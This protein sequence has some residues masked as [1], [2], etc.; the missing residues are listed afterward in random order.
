MANLRIGDF[1]ERATPNDG[2]KLLI[3][4]ENNLG[5]YHRVPVSAV[6]TG[7]GG[8]G[9]G[10]GSAQSFEKSVV[11]LSSDTAAAVADERLPL[12]AATA[13]N[14]ASLGWD[15]ANNRW[16]PTKAGWY[17]VTASRQYS[18]SDPNNSGLYVKKNAGLGSEISYRADRGDGAGESVTSP[19]IFCDGVNDYL[20]VW[21]HGDGSGSYTYRG[22]SSTNLWTWGACYRLDPV[23]AA[24]D[25]GG[26]ASRLLVDAYRSTA[27][28]IPGN[29]L[30]DVLF[31][32]ES[33]DLDSEYNPSTGEFT[34]AVAKEVTVTAKARFIFPPDGV[35]L[36]MQIMLDT[37]SGYSV[38]DFVDGEEAGGGGGGQGE[39]LMA[40]KRLQLDAGNK[41]KIAVQVYEATARD[42]GAGAH[43]TWL[44]IVEHSK[45]TPDSRTFVQTES[46]DGSITLTASGGSAPLLFPE[47]VD[48]LGD[49]DPSTG[50]VTIRRTGDYLVIGSIRVT[51]LDSGQFLSL[52]LHK[53]NGSGWDILSNENENGGAFPDRSPDLTMVLP[54]VKGDRIRISANLGAGSNKTL[55]VATGVNYFI[56][57]E[58]PGSPTEYSA[59]EAAWT[60]T[61][62]WSAE[63]T[64][65]FGRKSRQGNELVLRGKISANSAPAN[66]ILE[67]DL[68][69]G[70][71]IDTAKMALGFGGGHTP[72]SAHLRTNDGTSYQLGVLAFSATS[73]R[74]TRIFA[75][76]NGIQINSFTST[77][78]D[79]I[80]AG[81]TLSFEIR[82]PILGWGTHDGAYNFPS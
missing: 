47:I 72:G 21:S 5:Q 57:K 44:Q 16:K 11:Y 38:I 22:F 33:A 30:T 14:D 19:P 49:Y 29:A 43:Q 65:D 78:V 17:Q 63:S 2:D 48:R 3:E 71:Q 73:F 77:N 10:S 66:S 41:L 15:G 4:D 58:L 53:W 70:L 52:Y 24:V 25:G 18:G 35:R 45:S 9:G 12:D 6:G 61:H 34:A 27:Q 37:G 54:L 23:A 46:T 79:T 64:L 82:V 55:A 28:S 36:V 7:G 40:T 74:L 8:G 1:P 76:G 75:A 56:V 80:G 39:T 51:N 20:E 68:P 81:D 26:I 67:I 50:E 42:L 62:T 60:P 31:D 59:A 69:D 32:A 13:D